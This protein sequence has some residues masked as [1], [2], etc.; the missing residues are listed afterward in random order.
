MQALVDRMY[1]SYRCESSSYNISSFDGDRSDD[2]RFILCVAVLSRLAVIVLAVI[3]NVLIPDHRAQGVEFLH[4]QLVAGTNELEESYF[5]AL[6][7]PWHTFTKW[8][9]VFYLNIAVAGYTSH[10]K[11]FAFYPLYPAAIGTTMRLIQFL[12]KLFCGLFGVELQNLSLLARSVTAGL[13]VSN[14][15]FVSAAVVL[16]ELLAKLDASSAGRRNRVAVVICFIFNPATIF[17]ASIYTESLFA[18][19]SWLAMTC[20]LSERILVACICA[21]LSSLCRS[22]SALII[23]FY[24][25]CTAQRVLSTRIVLLAKLKYLLWTV[26]IC[27]CT[28]TPHLAWNAYIKY[29]I[30]ARA[31][32]PRD[33]I[34]DPHADS[35]YSRCSD[36]L[37]AADSAYSYVQGH[38]WD[39]GPFHYYQL[40]QLP[41]FCLALPIFVI[42]ARAV[43]LMRTSAVSTASRLLITSCRTPRMAFACHL[44]VCMLVLIVFAHIQISTRMLLSSSPIVNV[45]LHTYIELKRTRWILFCYF[46]VYV[47]GGIILHVNFY[48]W[49]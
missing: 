23:I 15:A 27:L 9:S 38:Y 19:L 1:S 11:Y 2:L 49:T 5:A 12:E 35:N 48:P 17:F 22:N 18:L 26:L 42:A 21:A 44:M 6:E 34:A 8:D 7:S 31:E 28:V 13:L 36:G 29:A 47:L 43:V 41:N 33:R 4:P 24:G 37:L 10:E 46:V 3:S 20:F 25:A 40:K 32:V 39:V 45:A 30:C 14:V 16:Y